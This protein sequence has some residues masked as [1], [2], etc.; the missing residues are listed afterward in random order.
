MATVS[1]ST[2]KTPGLTPPDTP[3]A[4]TTM[5]KKQVPATPPITRRS[6]RTSKPTS[7]LF[8]S[9]A[10]VHLWSLQGLS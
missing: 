9:N 3:P 6:T 1:S 8:R 5:G 7:K 4:L 2:M 10:L